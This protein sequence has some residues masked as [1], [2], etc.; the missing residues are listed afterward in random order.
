MSTPPDPL[1]ALREPVRPVT[2]DPAFAARLRERVEALVLDPSLPIEEEP[3]SDT[4]TT[5][6]TVRLRPGDLSYTSVW[7]ADAD[8]AARFYSAVLGWETR[9]DHGGR[10]HRVT[11]LRTGMG[12]YGGQSPTLFFAAVVDDVDAAVERVRAAGGTAGEPTEEPYGRIADCRDDQGLAFAVHEPPPGATSAAPS[13]MGHPGELAYV[14]IHVPDT[15]RARAFYGSVLGWGFSPARFPGNFSVEVG[16][17][18]PRPTMIG[19]GQH[20][21]EPAVVPMF[22]VRDIHAARDAAR[23]AGGTCTEPSAAGYATSCDGTDDQ[24]GQFYLGQF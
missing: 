6:S 14:A 24:G 11:N 8:A 3:M 12:I 21:G 2:P 16:G 20:D 15:D 5:D 1:D 10:G 23:A 9:S 7:T 19:V 22:A 17:G 13:D 18:S 4:T